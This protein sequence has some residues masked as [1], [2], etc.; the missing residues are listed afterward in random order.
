MT[1]T[2]YHG[3]CLQ[4]LKGI[5]DNSVDSAVMDPPA[6]ISFMGL[7]FDHD[8][9]GRD[10]WIAWL[11]SIMKECLRVLKPGGH[12]LVWALPRTSHWTGMA[13]ET[14]GF[15]VRD[16]ISYL[17][18]TNNDVSRFVDS[19][20]H[21]Q[22]G[23]LEIILSHGD[24]NFNTFAHIFGSGFP[25][26][27]NIGFALEKSKSHSYD[28]SKD[29]DKSF[30]LSIINVWKKYS[31]SAKY[32]EILSK[33]KITEIGMNTQKNAFAQEI[34]LLSFKT[35]KCYASALIAEL[36]CFAQ[37]HMQQE[38][39]QI[40][41]QG[42]AD[43]FIIQSPHL[44]KFVEL[45]LQDQNQMLRQTRSTAQLSVKESAKEKT[46]LKIKV[47]EVQ[48]ILHG[49]A[50]LSR[51]EII[52]A[53]CVELTSVLKLIILSQSKIFLNLDMKSQM[54]CVS[55][56]TATT[57][58][59]MAECLISSMV[60]TLKNQS[61]AVDKAVQWQGWGTALKPAYETWWLVRKPIAE[62]TVAANVLVWGT[63][64]INID[65][66]RV[67]VGGYDDYGRSAARSDGTMNPGI[68]GNGKGFVQQSHSQGRFPANLAHDGS[69]AVLAEFPK[70]HDRGNFN[71]GNW[72]QNNTWQ[73][74]ANPIPNGVSR[75]KGDG[76]AARF[77]YC[78]KAAPSEREVGLAEFE[79][80]DGNVTMGQFENRIE[81]GVVTNKKSTPKRANHHP[82]VKPVSLMRFFCKLITPTGGTVLDPFM[83][84]G[85]TGVGA[86]LEGFNFIGIEQE[87]DYFKIAQARIAHFANEGE[88]VANTPAPM[89][90]KPK[91]QQT[92]F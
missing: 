2:L 5:A 74:P 9:G 40:T 16:C 92:L 72:K 46:L 32:V 8:K 78:A 23:L 66:T 10:K 65:G 84:S 28:I 34:V 7:E 91:V 25:K 48:K 53:L 45:L 1:A 49:S 88:V 82:T 44:A 37:N 19:L 59:Y 18:D 17:Y 57:T 24:D 41:A 55:A 26:S 76:S 29:V 69:A 35:T 12:A 86:Q 80:R 42:S 83:G 11:S 3:D 15:E 31:S 6:G 67:D 58:E 39:M 4:V 90:P 52:S 36:R 87:L 71:A 61:D 20:S 14:A 27:L 30:I 22:R 47:E 38:E 73:G 77:F 85:T 68:W 50:K 60:D 21:E 89:P 13:L 56:I 75:G 70:V 33:K 43:T 79:E 81:N 62:D 63:G 51:E 54:E 64:G